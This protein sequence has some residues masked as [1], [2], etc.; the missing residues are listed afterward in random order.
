MWIASGSVCLQ[1][2]GGQE[3]V[4]VKEYGPDHVKELGFYHVV[5]I[6]EYSLNN[7]KD[8]YRFLF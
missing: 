1:G 2:K 7:F 8:G 5:I 3:I 6:I 4:Q